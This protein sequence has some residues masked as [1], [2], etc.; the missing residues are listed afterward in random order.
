MKRAD[1]DYK[2]SFPSS[3]ESHWFSKPLPNQKRKQC[4]K[5]HQGG[6]CN[7][8]RNLLNESQINHGKRIRGL[9]Q[10]IENRPAMTE[11]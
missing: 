10:L 11:D 5:G 6:F 1:E 4:M 8:D 7:N 9:E 2:F 3:G